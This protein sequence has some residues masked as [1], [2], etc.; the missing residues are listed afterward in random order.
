MKHYHR[1]AISAAIALA[2]MASASA[3]AEEA[4]T[5]AD[6]APAPAPADAKPKGPTLGDILGN[7]SID[8]KGYLDASYI[9]H[10]QTPNT[11]VQVFDT[12]KNS[13]GLHQA[14][15]TI[16]STPKEGF[17]GVLNLTAGSDAGIFCS[18]GGCGTSGATAGTGGNFD[19]TQAYAQYASGSWTFI[20]GKFATLAG[21]EVIDSSADTNIT[22]SI[23]F[24]KIPFTHTGFRATAALSDSTNLIMG[25]NNGW[26]Q[27]NDMNSSKTAELGLTTAFTKD[28]S[29][30]V[31]LYSGS[32]SMLPTTTSMVA[33]AVPGAVNGTRTLVDVVFTSNL[34]DTTTFILNGDHVSQDNVYGLG[35][36]KY[37][38]LAGYLNYQ[39]S[40]K[41]RLSLRA[42]ELRDDSGIAVATTGTPPG[43]N[44]LKEVTLTLGYAPV[45]NFELRGEVR[46]DH[47]DKAV[48]L[49]SNLIPQSTMLTVG[50]QGIYK[51]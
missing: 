34:T 9:S 25:L 20:G 36:E 18:Y 39:M 49:D 47:A 48:F 15:I 23:L 7:S 35:T 32:E 5:V 11:S 51:F 44:T 13:F 28:T 17:G 14:G 41:Y 12:T 42:E 31:S 33:T 8:V 10:S 38:G 40:E 37:W 43:S 3:R 21:A 2:V 24:G 16:S 50:V 26:D 29:L 1:S 19:V 30:A 6:A 46:S 45:K 27:V 4:V 22:R